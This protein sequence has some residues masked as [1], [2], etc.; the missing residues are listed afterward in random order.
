MSDNDFNT[1]V[2][3]HIPSIAPTDSSSQTVDLTALA[4]CML[5]NEQAIA[6][7]KKYLEHHFIAGKITYKDLEDIENRAI[8]KVC[9]CLW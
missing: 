4:M 1:D 3:T 7:V 9:D 8:R 2:S 6:A 5:N